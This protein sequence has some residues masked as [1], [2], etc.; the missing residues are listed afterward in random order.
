MQAP[1][2]ISYFYKI[3]LGVGAINTL[4]VDEQLKYLAQIYIAHLKTFPYQ[5]FELRQISLQHPLQRNSLEANS[6]TRLVRTTN[7]GFC[8]QLAQLLYSVLHPL[9]FNVK[10]CSARVL[11]GLPVNSKELLS[12]PPTHLILVV[13]LANHSYL[14]D[15]GLGSRAPRV[16][17]P[18]TSDRET[19]QLALDQFRG[20]FVEDIF[21]VE[22]KIN[23]QWAQ[24]IQTDL[25]PLNDSMIQTLMLK[26]E[27]FPGCIEIRDTKTIASRITDVGNKNFFWSRQ[28]NDFQYSEETNGSHHKESV[29][30]NVAYQK[31]TTEIGVNPKDDTTLKAYCGQGTTPKPKRRWSLS[32]IL[33]PTELETMKS[34]LTP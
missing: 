3:G 10:R 20:I 21:V 9:G 34:N 22:K 14:L 18:I 24:I 1:D 13:T 23:N 31:L 2:F 25:K 19:H 4:S 8:Y 32:T 17:L 12:I 27:R 28:L 6:F 30:R 26:L 16:P 5:N 29:T 7:G 15:P 11:N 33:H